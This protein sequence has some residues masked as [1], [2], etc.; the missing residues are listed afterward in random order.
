MGPVERPETAD[1]NVI[2]ADAEDATADVAIGCSPNWELKRYKEIRAA[3]SSYTNST[4][5]SSAHPSTLITNI[6]YI[7]HHGHYPSRL[8]YHRCL[9]RLWS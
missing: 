8:V 5:P 9:I 4:E 6:T 2:S 1:M 7:S 3:S